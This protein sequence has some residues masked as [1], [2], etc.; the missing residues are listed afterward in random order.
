MLDVRIWEVGAGLS[1]RIKTPS[2]QNH[3]IDLGNSPNFSPSEYISQNH[4]A[5][6][7]EVD[8][9]VISHT[10]SDHYRDLPNF[11][12][13]LG[14][15]KALL[16]NKSIPAA[17]KYGNEGSEYQRV[18]K[19]LDQEYTT[20]VPSETSPMNP[21]VNGGVEVASSMLDWDDALSKNNSS[22]VVCYKYA[23]VLFVF[24]GDIEEYGWLKLR[25]KKPDLFSDVLEEVNFSI[26][27]APHHGRKSGYSK[28][29]IDFF[30]PNI[31]VISDGYGAGETDPRF[32]TSASGVH[33]FGVEKKFV[34]TKSNGRKQLLVAP[35]GQVNFH[36][37]A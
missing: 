18:Y 23:G 6:D 24:P 27:V 16:R 22:I 37:F 32:R 1:I 36:D 34:T 21:F 28:D 11:V 26:L 31:I 30:K 10:D 5:A 4:W 19:T 3:F 15:P 12:K 8:F 33:I 29:M 20:S 13:L 25:Q 17:E 14:K 2:G 9:L 35:N 7:D